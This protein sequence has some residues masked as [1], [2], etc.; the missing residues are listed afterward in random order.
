VEKGSHAESSEEVKRELTQEVKKDFE[1]TAVAREEDTQEGREEG[2]RLGLIPHR[3]KLR[4]DEQRK[5]RGESED[6][7]PLRVWV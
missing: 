4:R 7:V 3:N 6:K 1:E 5:R 2:G